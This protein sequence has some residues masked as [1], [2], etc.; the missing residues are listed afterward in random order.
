MTEEKKYPGLW[1]SR[2]FSRNMII[3]GC[4]FDLIRW[5]I[6]ST[7]MPKTTGTVTRFTTAAA[8]TR[9]A[10]ICKW[11]RI[12]HI[13]ASNNC[14]FILFFCVCLTFAVDRR[15]AWLPLPPTQKEKIPQKFLV[16]EERQHL[17]RLA[18]L[19]HVISELYRH[20]KRW[21]ATERNRSV[22]AWKPSHGS[23]NR[24]HI[25]PKF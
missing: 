12:Q 16:K 9:R 11:T 6:S 5:C 17:A 15:V 22:S 20:V 13:Y 2:L 25:A 18:A 23:L 10:L 19:C 21:N 1:D 7:L 4:V 8:Q 3:V 24:S 14:I